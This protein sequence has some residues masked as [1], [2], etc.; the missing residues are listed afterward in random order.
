MTHPNRP[1][2]VPAE[3]LAQQARLTAVLLA[4]EA[5]APS[6]EPQPLR[7]LRELVRGSGEWESIRAG[8]E[9]ADLAEEGLEILRSARRHAK[10]PVAVQTIMRDL[11][12][13]AA[14]ARKRREAIWHL[15]SRRV[16]VRFRYAKTGDALDF[17][18][19]DIQVLL[20]WALRLEGLVV[21]LDLGHHGRPMIHLG[22]PLPRGVGGDGEWGDVVLKR[23][24]QVSAEDLMTRVN[25]RVP[26]GIRL[27]AW[28]DIPV[29][30]SPVAELAEYASW[31][32]NCPA[33][34]LEGART[35]TQAFLAAETFLWDKSGKVG[36]QKLEKSLDLRT[37]IQSLAWEG[38][39]LRAVTRMGPYEATNPLKVF[40]VVLG[41]D[42]ATLQGLMREGLMLRADPRL[43]RADRFEPKLKNMYEDAVV[44]SGGSNIILVD[45]EDDEP[46]LLG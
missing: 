38:G 32:W 23:S 16:S 18:T 25:L 34:A 39:R 14:K 2:S 17:D 22:P 43:A 1:S 46:L 31:R 27:H 33:E 7:A 5:A 6:R 15:D 30:A 29:Y 12:P 41:L 45:E 26:V 11:E 20:L 40:G 19:G 36:G 28:E 35:R 8:L 42:P 4:A 13:L 9:A 44:L 3:V 37:V 21:A 10:D 24:P